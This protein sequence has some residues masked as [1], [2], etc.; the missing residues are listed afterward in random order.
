MA[1]RASTK[2]VPRRGTMPKSGAGPQKART[3]I[4]VGEPNPNAPHGG[5]NQTHVPKPNIPKAKI[6]KP[7]T[8]PIKV[9]TS[10]KK[11]MKQG[12]AVIKKRQ[13]GI[14]GVRAKKQYARKLKRDQNGKS[15][16]YDWAGDG[17]RKKDPDYGSAKDKAFK[18]RWAK[19]HPGKGGDGNGKDK[20]K[21][22]PKPKPRNNNGD[23]GPHNDA[24]NADSALRAANDK[25]HPNFN[26]HSHDLGSNRGKM[27]RK[28]S[29]KTS[30][31]Y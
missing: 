13:H 23:G 17:A 27:R 11:L 8:K 22:K 30:L 18:A 19:K 24:G 5:R 31:S 20:P 25:N 4:R 16:G 14:S 3:S 12:V 29:H 26:G 2:R 28:R 1:F 7:T 21:P 6:H 15:G 10:A 9:K